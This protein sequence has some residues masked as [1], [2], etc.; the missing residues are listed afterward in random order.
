MALQPGIEGSVCVELKLEQDRSATKRL[1]KTYSYWRYI[2]DQCRD[3]TLCGHVSSWVGCN[4]PT[5]FCGKSG[6]HATRLGRN[7]TLG[8][9]IRV[10]AASGGMWKCHSCKAWS[11]IL[12]VFVLVVE[13]SKEGQQL[14]LEHVN[15][16]TVAGSL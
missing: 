8:G 3:R 10:L 14:V 2:T 15:A 9:Q 11:T 12:S 13:V 5:N 16:L 1:E 6:V 7:R 4:I